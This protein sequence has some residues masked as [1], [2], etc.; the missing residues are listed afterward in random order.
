[1]QKGTSHMEIDLSRGNQLFKAP[2]YL[3]WI[4]Q[5]I[6][7]KYNVCSSLN[8]PCKCIVYPFVWLMNFAQQLANF[9]PSQAPLSLCCSSRNLAAIN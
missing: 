3:Y 2:Y 9:K 1:M 5:R 6:E 8:T 7:N 4:N